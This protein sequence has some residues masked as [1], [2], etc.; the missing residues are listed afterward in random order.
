MAGALQV[1]AIITGLPEKNKV[2][3]TYTPHMAPH[4]VKA[5]RDYPWHLGG[6]GG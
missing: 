4:R 5:N 6:D 3:G 1:L 2:V